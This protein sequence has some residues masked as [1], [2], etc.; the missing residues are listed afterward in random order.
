MGDLLANDPDLP[1]AAQIFTRR[2][3]GRR[4]ELAGEVTGPPDLMRQTL[5]WLVGGIVKQLAGL[6]LNAYRAKLIATNSADKPDAEQ[7]VARIEAREP[8]RWR[9][10]PMFGLRHP[11]SAG[12]TTRRSVSG[13]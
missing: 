2:T 5:D 8:S 3:G 9:N 11:G 1:A 4:L 10:R 13:G 7:A 6:M 12:S